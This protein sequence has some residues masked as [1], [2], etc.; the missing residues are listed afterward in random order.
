M[1]LSIKSISEVY[2]AIGALGL[3]LVLECEILRMRSA[4]RQNESTELEP[5]AFSSRI[6]PFFVLRGDEV[7]PSKVTQARRS[8]GEHVY[9][10]DK[11]L[12]ETARRVEIALAILNGQCGGSPIR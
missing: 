6:D 5:Q 10:D 1:I 2:R 9:D 3:S 8:L 11:I 12:G 4:A 7:R